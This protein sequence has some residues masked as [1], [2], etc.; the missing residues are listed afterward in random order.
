MGGC[1]LPVATGDGYLLPLMQGLR[2]IDFT[3]HGHRIWIGVSPLGFLQKQVQIR[4]QGIGLTVNCQGYSL[5]SFGSLLTV[6]LE[7]FH[8]AALV[9]VLLLDAVPAR[10]F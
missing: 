2:K 1:E 10:L 9:V 5:L 6:A 3:E 8:L 7:W 4:V